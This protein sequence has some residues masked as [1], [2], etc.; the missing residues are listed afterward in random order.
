MS[1]RTVQPA[2]SIVSRNVRRFG[3][4]VRLDMIEE[5]VVLEQVI[6]KTYNINFARVGSGPNAIILMPGAV[7]S[8]ETDFRPQIDGLPMLLNNYTI[9]AWDPPGY[10]KSR[11]PER[12]F[13]VGFYHRDA[14]LADALMRQLGFGKYS[15][16]GWSDGGTT[17]LIMASHYPD[18]VRK[19]AIWGAGPI[20][21]RTDVEICQSIQSKTICLIEAKSI[22]I[23]FNF[24]ER[25][26]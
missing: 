11:P 2:I 1:L 21:N 6:K 9:I 20:I 12:T 19:L 18:A 10:G 23:A 8:I 5:N 26:S 3:T 25:Y 24:I 16:I 15:I 4:K 7:G 14:F 13:P 17:G 22:S